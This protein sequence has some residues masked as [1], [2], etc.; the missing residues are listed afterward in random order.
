MAHGGIANPSFSIHLWCFSTDV[1]IMINLEDWLILSIGTS[2]VIVI[3]QDSSLGE[4]RLSL[5]GCLAYKHSSCFS[6]F[7]R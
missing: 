5:G 3:V 1:I 6:S 2:I 4:K 7:C